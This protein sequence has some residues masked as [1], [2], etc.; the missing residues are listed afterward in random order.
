MSSLLVHS[1]FIFPRSKYD[2]PPTHKS[3]DQRS[4]F[5]LNLQTYETLAILSPPQVV[6][7]S[8]ITESSTNDVSV[9]YPNQ[10]QTTTRTHGFKHHSLSMVD[11][12]SESPP[13]EPTISTTSQHHPT[14]QKP[15]NWHHMSTTQRRNWHKHNVSLNRKDGEG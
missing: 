8:H 2:T 6:P 14:I 9:N 4:E 7:Q 3:H 10:E 11:I 13:Q 1:H 15:L 12:Q 5:L